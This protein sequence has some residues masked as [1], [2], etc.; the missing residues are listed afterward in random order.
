M[1][2][3]QIRSV[4]DLRLFRS[5]RED[6]LVQRISEEIERA[7]DGSGPRTRRHLLA[8]SVRLDRSM[9][10]SLH[11]MADQ[12]VTRLGIETPLELYAYNSPDFNA[13]CFKPEAGRVFIMFSSGLLQAFQ[14]DELLFV[15]GHELG[16]HVY[17]HHEVPIG[18]LLHGQQQPSAELALQL[19]AWS[20][21]AEI[22]ADRAGA[23]C[24]QNQT[25]VTR[26][27]F[28]LA[29]GLTDDSVVRFD[30]DN[31]L[32]QVDDMTVADAE[33]G[34]GAPAQDWFSTHP[35]SPLRVK[36]LVQFERSILMRDGGMAKE[37]LELRVQEAMGLMEPSYVKGTSAVTKAMRDLLVAGAV[38]VA[39]ADSELGDDETAVLEKFFD[40]EL[41][42]SKLKPARLRQVLPARIEAVRVQAS[43]SRR[44]QVVRDL[45][46]IARA[47]G[48][49]GA[50]ELKVLREICRGLDISCS[51]VLQRVEDS[52]ELD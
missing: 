18:Y 24:A 48:E 10:E 29:S 4:N 50:P 17:D 37:D 28:K 15:M 26:A 33:P 31:F 22:S 5:L 49:I 39:T 42:V 51:F 6:R 34:Q 13:A 7:E 43:I 30:L 44:M 52:I 46:V 9:A 27:L 35:F 12:C 20:R 47:D 16:H 40:D 36:A 25:A 2:A 11:A 45:C 1:N 8:T 21:Y 14:H 38:A 19:F 32:S 41:D 3:E 23:F